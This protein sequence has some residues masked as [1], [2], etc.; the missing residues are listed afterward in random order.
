MPAPRL[1]HE[2]VVFAFWRSELRP[3]LPIIEEIADWVTDKQ[4]ALYQLPDVA[5]PDGMALAD[6]PSSEEQFHSVVRFRQ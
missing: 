2:A 3:A 4:G 1:S 5:K 6:L